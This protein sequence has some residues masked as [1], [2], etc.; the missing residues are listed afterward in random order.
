MLF[1]CEIVSRLRPAPQSRPK[2][3]VCETAVCGTLRLKPTKEDRELISSLP[4]EIRRIATLLEPFLARRPDLPGLTA[5][6]L[7]QISIYIDLL[8][9][10]NARINLTALRD[11]DQIV[12]RHFGESLFAARHL[13]GGASSGSLADPVLAGQGE[14][15]PG[16][17]PV[18]IVVDLGSGAGFPGLPLKVWSPRVRVTLIE[19]NRKKVAFLREVIRF[20][21][22]TDTDVFPGRA[23]TFPSASAALV[24]LRA[25]ERFDETLPAAI[26]LL[27]PGGSLALLIGQAQSARARHLA[28]TLAWSDPVPIP[29]SDARILLSGSFRTPSESSIR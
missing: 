20:L 27:A 1:L 29:L 13:F 24:V 23:Q 18:P 15:T 17:D 2:S 5:G 25:V 16:R 21:A 10:W 9:R 14:D 22:L 6:Q 19:S 4:M 11:P 3:S 8:L 26:R 28:P 7:E 12:T